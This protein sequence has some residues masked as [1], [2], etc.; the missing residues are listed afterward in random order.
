ME[1]NPK[2]FETL[3]EKATDYG[4]VSLELAKLKTAEKTSDVVSSFVPHLV[5]FILFASFLLFIN[6][7][8]ALWLGVILGNSFVGFFIVAAFYCIASLVIYFLLHNWIKKHI[9]EYLVRQLFK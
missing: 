6:L 8:L 4:K 7:G 9:Y 2:L 3:F 5:V 1:E